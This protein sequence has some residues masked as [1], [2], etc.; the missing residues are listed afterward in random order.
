MKPGDNLPSIA[1]AQGVK[2]KD[3]RAANANVDG[4]HMQVR[5]EV[6]ADPLPNLFRTCFILG[7]TD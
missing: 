3:L 2:L 4:N 5:P 1:K 6:V 7:G